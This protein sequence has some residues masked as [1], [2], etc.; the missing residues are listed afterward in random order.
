METQFIEETAVLNQNFSLMQSKCAKSVH[1]GHNF[2]FALGRDMIIKPPKSI[3]KKE[4]KM[5]RPKN[6]VTDQFE[7]QMQPKFQIVL[8]PSQ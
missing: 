7:P 4:G 2:V 3:K 6:L 1:C 5:A 8:S